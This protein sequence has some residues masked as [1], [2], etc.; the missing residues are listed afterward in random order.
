MST[1]DKIENKMARSIDKRAKVYAVDQTFISEFKD[2]KLISVQY[3]RISP[4]V[5]KRKK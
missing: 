5:V 3:Q 4:T 1:L 2:K